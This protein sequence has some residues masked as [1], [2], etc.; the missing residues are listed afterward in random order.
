MKNGEEELRGYLLRPSPTF[1]RQIGE[2]IEISVSSKVLERFRKQ[3]HTWTGGR[4]AQAAINRGASDAGMN[5]VNDGDRTRDNR[6]HNPVLYQ[7]SYIHRVGRL[8]LKRDLMAR[9]RAGLLLIRPFGASEAVS[10]LGMTSERVKSFFSSV[11]EGS[12]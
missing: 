12:A 6:N 4:K 2:D 1:R 3:P 11:N 7:L 5:G 8:V 10:L 9:L